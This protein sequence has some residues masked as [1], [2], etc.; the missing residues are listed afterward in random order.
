M[1]SPCPAPELITALFAGDR[2]PKGA[3]EILGHVEG[4]PA[5][6]DTL[7]KVLPKI[8]VPRAFLPDGFWATPDDTNAKNTIVQPLESSLGVFSPA[9]KA[10]VRDVPRRLGN[11]DVLCVLGQGGM[12]MVLK[13]L[14]PA[15]NRF[16]A[17]KI[18]FP[19]LASNEVYRQR[20]SREA[21]SAAMIGSDHATA[22]YSV[23]EDGDSP[24]IV[25]E[26]IAGENLETRLNRD[27]KLPLPLAVSVARQVAAGLAAA[28][29][30]GIVHR[31]I[32]PANIM[33]ENTSG[34]DAKAAGDSLIR[35]K[36][37]DFG[38]AK[39]QGSSSLT[40][41]QETVGTPEYMSPEQI[42]GDPLDHR[43]DL[44]SVRA[45]RIT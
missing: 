9:K 33:L 13:A 36:I 6:R 31:D 2:P 43:S 34:A 4:C 39:A 40:G 14:D 35:V 18:L 7:A 16:A 25:M 45:R 21:R 26:Y 24:Y 12:G 30:Q 17:V 38:I 5:C 11:Y 19:E 41:A 20:F 3:R 44:Y 22:V 27:G 10:P 37:T 23:G 15:L 42:S 8:E 28:H 32:K 29:A 1:N